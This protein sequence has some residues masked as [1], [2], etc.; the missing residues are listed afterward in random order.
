MAVVF[1]FHFMVVVNYHKAHSFLTCSNNSAGL[2][3][4]AVSLKQTFQPF[5]EHQIF[6]QSVTCAHRKNQLNIY[7]STTQL[8]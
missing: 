2:L 7:K 1:Q 4:K 5:N 3:A 6:K 8:L